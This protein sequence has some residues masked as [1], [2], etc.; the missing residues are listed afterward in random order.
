MSATPV[1][2][3]TSSVSTTAASV[4]LSSPSSPVTRSSIAIRAF[5]ATACPSRSDTSSARTPS[6][7]A[8][9]SRRRRAADR[10]AVPTAWALMTVPRDDQDP[11]S[12]GVS[13]ESMVT[14][15]IRD[16]STP[17][18]EA[19]TCAITVFWPVPGSAPPNRA[20]ISP[21]ART[22]MLASARFACS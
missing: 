4:T 12:K 14:T 1:A 16:T 2:W 8:A 3:F 20:R 9:S 18:S 15:V 13:S 21:S 22:S 5:P 11:R 19:A 6:L 7:S 17:S 10:A